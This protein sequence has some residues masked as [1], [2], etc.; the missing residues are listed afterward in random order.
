MWPSPDVTLIDLR[1]AELRAAQ[2]LPA[3]PNRVLTVSLSEIEEG[4]H[5]LTPGLGPLL[6]VCERGVRSM[7]AARL[8]RSDGLEATAYAGGV[9]ALIAASLGA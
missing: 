2:P 8:L 3:L 6:V 7:L 5:T 1:S 4:A 9:P